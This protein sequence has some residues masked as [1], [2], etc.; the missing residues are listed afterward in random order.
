VTLNTSLC[1]LYIYRDTSPLKHPSWSISATPQREMQE[2]S[3]NAS[4]HRQGSYLAKDEFQNLEISMFFVWY[5]M[6]N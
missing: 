1:T 3:L 6:N 2:E 4:S 5:R